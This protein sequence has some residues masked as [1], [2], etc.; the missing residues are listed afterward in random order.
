MRSLFEISKSGLRSAERSLSVTSNNIVN[1]DTKGYSRQRIDKTPNGMK[2]TGYNTGLGVNISNVT[3]LR[4]EMNDVMLN[5][6]RQN[7]SF[8]QSKARVF[9][10]LEASMASDS[11]S[12]LDLSISNLLDTFSELSTDPQDISVRN[13]LISDARQMTTKFKDVSRN[14]DRTSDLILESSNSTI[15]AING[16]LGEIHSLNQT[17]AQADAAGAPD[18]TSLDLRV[19]KLEELSELTDYEI[20]A[21]DSNAVELRIGGVKVLDAEKADH[22]KAEINDVDKTYQIRL[23]SGKTVEPQGG[24][25]GAELE[26]YQTEIPALK[27]RLDELASTIVTEF[28]AIH[29]GGY[30]LNDN[31]SRNFFN[32]TNTTADTISLNQVL[33]DDPTNIAA[34]DTDGEAGNGETALQIAELRSQQL[35]GGRKL[36]D[37]SVDLITSAGNSLSSLNSQIEARDSEIQM[38][39]TQQEREAGV[40]IDEELSLMIQYQNAY[41][42]AAKVMS[43]AQ[44]MYDTLIGILR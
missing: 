2:M 20:S 30:G 21:N 38:L 12:D 29:S 9:E 3:R 10:Q 34:S 43:A 22:L 8:M 41:Q 28:N 13:S 40:N 25:L 39:T 14:I 32:P 5:E 11:G 4:N 24:Q 27:D 33:V 37:Y 36:I 19:R 26:M 42:G 6:K 31:V 35:I 23:E 15:N 16:L 18:N 17:I 1:A 44:N 7:M